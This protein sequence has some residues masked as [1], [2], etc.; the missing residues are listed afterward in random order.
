VKLN[1]RERGER[2]RG[3]KEIDRK[4]KTLTLELNG[5]RRKR[6]VLGRTR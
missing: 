1:P 3:L 4:G 5:T 2:E 6:R